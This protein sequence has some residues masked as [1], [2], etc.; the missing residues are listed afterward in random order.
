MGPKRDETNP[1]TG[2]GGGKSTGK[3]TASGSGTAPEVVAL[4]P[5]ALAMVQSAKRA[6]AQHKR[7]L[8]RYVNDLESLLGDV[9]TDQ[10]Y[11]PHYVKPF[12][13]LME[14]IE[15]QRFKIEEKYS[16][17]C[18]L[19]PTKAA[20]YEEAAL[21]V[22]L[23]PT[24]ILSRAIQT[25]GAIRVARGPVPQAP[26]P[27]PAPVPARHA[28]ANTALQPEKLELDHSPS[29]LDHWVSRFMAFYRTSNLDTLRLSDQREYLA[30]SL[31]T[32]VYQ[33]LLAMI[34][35]QTPIFTEGGDEDPSCIKALRKIWTERY[36]LFQRRHQYF[37]V[38]YS[39]KIQDLP[40]FLSRLEELGRVAEISKMNE[41]SLNAYRALASVHDREL[42]RLCWREE[43]L[44][45]DRFRMLALERVREQENFEATRKQAEALKVRYTPQ[46]KAERKKTCW[47]CGEAGHYAPD[48][49][50][51]KKPGSQR[52]S[53][54][55]AQ[56]SRSGSKSGNKKKHG[57]KSS[58]K[59][60]KAR[61]AQAEAASSS[62]SS[63]YTEDEDG[64]ESSDSDQSKA[65]ANVSK[66]LS[67]MIN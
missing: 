63:S 24:P 45:M 25:L 29:E 61:T 38:D 17:L 21:A 16:E 13:D 48:C 27:A 18:M 35:D 66:V 31:S 58:K 11:S 51:K 50:S 53:A 55:K 32:P 59:K 14:K 4:T 42:R 44:D 54:R 28:K 33:R 49:P 40:G 56:K 65:S 9:D 12:Y 62:G 7:H 5:E 6:V 64:H 22:A 34:D 60:G 1:G 19:D 46:D 26:G 37:T 2:G 36:P 52:S 8:T 30:S 3:G 10:E 41:S 47:T 15:D 39:G 67:A 23:Q 43:N 20:E 57:H